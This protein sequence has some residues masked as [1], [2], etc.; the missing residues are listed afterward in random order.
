[1]VDDRTM[2]P[3]IVAANNT[4][5][6]IVA[7]DRRSNDA[8]QI[9]LGQEFEAKG[10]EYVHRR[11]NARKPANSIF[12]DQV[13]QMLCAFGGNL[14]VAIRAK[15][16]IFEI[17]TTYNDVFPNTLGI[18]HV[19]GIQTLGWAYDIVKRELKAKSDSGSMTDLEQRQLREPLNKSLPPRRG[20]V[21]M[22]VKALIS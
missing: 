12:A 17:D 18:D 16:D 15:A 9:R 14:Q 19:F 21:R 5:N 6:A 7:W 3:K 1:M 4:L 22:G 13:G 8:V 2:I 11:D 10:I 20:K